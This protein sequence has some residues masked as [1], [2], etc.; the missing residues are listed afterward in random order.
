MRLRTVEVEFINNGLLQTFDGTLA[1][2][3]HDI[4]NDDFIL[5]F[6]QPTAWHVERLLRTDVPV[7]THGMTVDIDLSL[8]PVLEVEESVAHLIYIK[9]AAIV[10]ATEDEVFAVPGIAHGAA[11]AHHADG[12]TI[13]RLFL[14]PLE[15]PDSNIV[16]VGDTHILPHCRG[17]DD[18]RSVD[19]EM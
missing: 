6:L 8:A 17:I 9:V 12:L 1:T 14:L 19:A 11:E 18:L 2:R 7:A 15:C 3:A 4:E 10:A 5:T 13:G 16:V